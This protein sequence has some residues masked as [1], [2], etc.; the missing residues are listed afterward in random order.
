LNPVK[1]R[2]RQ[3][4]I[5]DEPEDLRGEIAEHRFTRPSLV[6]LFEPTHTRETVNR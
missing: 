4:Q 3:T 6:V 5:P 1:D 2:V